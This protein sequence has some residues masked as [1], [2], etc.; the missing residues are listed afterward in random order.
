MTDD[1]ESFERG[2]GDM[3]KRA[4]DKVGGAVDKA[5]DAI[6]DAAKRAGAG[7]GRLAGNDKAQS[8]QQAK[9]PVQQTKTP[10]S[11]PK[12]STGEVP[13]VMPED[14]GER[15]ERPKG[16]GAVTIGSNE[17]GRTPTGSD[18]SPSTTSK[19]ASPEAE[20]TPREGEGAFDIPSAEGAVTSAPESVSTDVRGEGQSGQYSD[21]SSAGASSRASS[22]AHIGTSAGASGGYDID[23]LRGTKRE[24]L[25]RGAMTGASA[26][27]DVVGGVAG[28]LGVARDLVRTALDPSATGLKEA[29]ALISAT[30][31]AEDV[32]GGA[33][34]DLTKT[35]Q[36]DRRRG[37]E[38]IRANMDKQYKALIDDIGGGKPIEGFD[39]EQL[40]TLYQRAKDMWDEH[41]RQ[42]FKGLDPTTEEAMK[43]GYGSIMTGIRNEYKRRATEGT[44]RAQEL[45]FQTKDS[46]R[47]AADREI[48]LSRGWRE[49]LDDRDPQAILYDKLTKEL[50]VSEEKAAKTIIRD[51]NGASN[52]VL[53]HMNTHYQRVKAAK[54]AGRVYWDPERE[55]E[56]SRTPPNDPRYKAL[57]DE[58]ERAVKAGTAI[59]SDDIERMDII[60]AN[61]S[62]QDMS[63]SRNMYIA[64]VDNV[65]KDLGITDYADDPTSKAV[66]ER[67]SASHKNYKAVEKAMKDFEGDTWSVATRVLSP[68]EQSKLVTGYIDDISPGIEGYAR[69]DD[70]RDLRMMC[71]FLTVNKDVIEQLASE[72]KV[73]TNKDP[74]GQ[75][76]L[77]T[78]AFGR[79]RGEPEETFMGW[80]AENSN[81]DPQNSGRSVINV[82]GVEYSYVNEFD[83]RI[84]NDDFYEGAFAL[85]APRMAEDM[86]DK[87]ADPSAMSDFERKLFMNGMRTNALTMAKSRKSIFEKAGKMGHNGIVS[88]PLEYV[89]ESILSDITKALEGNVQIVGEGKDGEKGSIPLHIV[90]GY[91]NKLENRANLLV[92][93]SIAKGTPLVSNDP[94][95][96][97]EYERIRRES[98]GLMKAV[99]NRMGIEPPFSRDARY[100][101]DGVSGQVLQRNNL[102][103][104]ANLL[105]MMMNT[106]QTGGRND[107]QGGTN[108][109]A[110]GKFNSN[111]WYTKDNA[112]QRRMM[113]NALKDL[114]AGRTR[115]V[116]TILSMFQDIAKYAVRSGDYTTLDKMMNQPN[117]RKVFKK[118]TESIENDHKSMAALSKKRKENLLKAL[119]DLES[120][121]D[122]ANGANPK[123]AFSKKLGENK[124][125][126][127]RLRAAVKVLV[128]VK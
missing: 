51:A 101:P 126:L 2:L 90:E 40:S 37:A 107:G 122:I 102:T 34:G 67:A 86:F 78:G 32:A 104:I 75:F 77:P 112:K 103:V 96:P 125:S 99:C 53:N 8:P 74:Y 39:D 69:S 127:G 52:A 59:F 58:R 26:L 110:P 30:G 93:E 79:Y 116:N 1:S 68:V 89:D 64:R 87:L 113:D 66:V 3:A 38:A 115:G 48:E 9:T 123:K 16:K 94:K 57:L 42:D 5:K 121:M 19:T 36:E 82:G 50:G 63:S 33:L 91:V 80:L 76:G 41:G 65:A 35:G 60:N 128:P 109:K 20:T 25:G 13:T 28:G 27:G 49:R 108:G 56:L 7:I 88:L 97:S 71:N 11:S 45:R 15:P 100:T 85:F 54:A 31:K 12:Q 105:Y 62:K 72:Y 120:V 70:A 18:G 24:R 92:Q 119:D 124:I 95:N 6:G 83:K 14:D 46:K 17:G 106:S 61:K 73:R 23:S 21:T 111:P 98:D 4:K 55:D 43:A 10:Q 22:G 114:Q 117:M 118:M 44:T 84:D 47:E 81:P 29:G